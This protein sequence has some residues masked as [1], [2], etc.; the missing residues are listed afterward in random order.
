MVPMA[1]RLKRATP[2]GRYG[3]MV[4]LDMVNIRGKSDAPKGDTGAAKRLKT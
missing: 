1:E 4:R 2:E 3:A